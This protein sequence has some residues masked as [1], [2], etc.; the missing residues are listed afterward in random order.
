VSDEHWPL[1][2]GFLLGCQSPTGPYPL[3]VLHGEQGSGKS[4][5]AKLLRS[6]ID[7]AKPDHRG[8]PENERD[9]MIAAK[10]ARILAFD[11]LS[12]LGGRGSAWVSDA[13]CRLS[14]G[15]GYAT[16]ALYSNDEEQLF[17]VQRPVILNGIDALPQRS[18]LLS[19]SLLVEL[20]RLPER[21]VRTDRELSRD[22]EGLLPLVLG[23]LLDATVA[24]LANRDS[25]RLPNKPRMADHVVWVT[26]AEGA[27]DWTPGTYHASYAASRQ[28][29]TDAALEASPLSPYFEAVADGE[30]RTATELLEQ[31][32]Q[33]AGEGVTKQR[34]WPSTPT[35]LSSQLKRLA[36]DL[37]RIGIEVDRA[38]D[39]R[40]AKRRKTI[41]LRQDAQFSDPSDP[42]D[43]TALQSQIA[44][45]H[46]VAGV[47]VGSLD[48]V[49][50]GRTGSLN[51]SG[52][53]PAKTGMGSL[54][55]L[56][57]LTSKEQGEEVR[58]ATAAGRDEE[59]PDGD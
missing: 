15:G 23:G 45:S 6:V 49:A 1:I 32:E 56:G 48:G 55:S 36:P 2:V 21:E 11:N 52:E 3:L 53:T 41:R 43:P 4:T 35:Q 40:G 33:L 39:G 7:P 44:G 42:S 37:R 59:P 10:N 25:V 14:T 19:R 50:R 27:L 34:G 13:L 18:D 47:A 16:R 26:A 30:A 51:G 8:L 29:A 58:D 22:F 20:P 54:G 5:T 57:S 9:L 46:G 38:S 31:L 24:A 17:D 28:D 12:G